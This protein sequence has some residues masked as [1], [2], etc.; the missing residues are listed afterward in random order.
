[1]ITFNNREE[2]QFWEACVTALCTQ[3]PTVGYVTSVPDAVR[4]A[5]TFIE[6]RRKRM[7]NLPPRP[8]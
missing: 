7:A 1:M 8:L 4:L 6:E 5:D 2:C 3:Q